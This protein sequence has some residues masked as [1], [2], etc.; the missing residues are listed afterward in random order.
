VH[1]SAVIVPV[2]VHAEVFL[3]V[4]VHRTLVVFVEDVFEVFCMLAPNV[5]YSE[6]V[7]A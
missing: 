5:F 1:F 3:S 2:D 4:P 6:V 7:D